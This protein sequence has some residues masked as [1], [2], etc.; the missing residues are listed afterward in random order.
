MCTG[1]NKFFITT[2]HRFKFFELSIS[3]MYLPYI[4]H[5][6]VNDKRQKELFVEFDQF[7]YPTIL[8]FS[9]IAILSPAYKCFRTFHKKMI[10]YINRDMVQML[11]LLYLLFWALNINCFIFRSK[12]NNYITIQNLCTTHIIENYSQIVL[13]FVVAKGH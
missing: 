10:F 5:Y 11:C 9:L 1:E 7:F 6:Y 2:K 8:Q 4:I 12:K 3:N 13:K